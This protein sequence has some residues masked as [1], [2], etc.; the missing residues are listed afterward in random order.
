MQKINL[1]LHDRPIRYTGIG[2]RTPHYQTILE[3]QPNIPW[4]E[5]LS[6]NYFNDPHQRDFLLRLR[7]E[8]PIALHGVGLSLGSTDPLNITYLKQLKSLVDCIQPKLISDHLSWTSVA[9]HH[10]HDL[11]PLPMTDEV[12][13]HVSERIQHVQDYLGRQI[14]IENPSSY[15]GLAMD[16]MPEWEFVNA[17][18]S[19]ADCHVL[20][21]INN[22]A[23][24]AFNQQFNADTYLAEIDA[25]RVKQYHLAG[26][27]DCSDHLFDQHNQ[28]VHEDVWQLYEKAL[29]IIGSKPTLIERDD[30]IPALETLIEEAKR[31]DQ[32]IQQA[33]MTHDIAC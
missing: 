25:T 29:S 32:L 10:L 5:A 12:V 27:T 17:I 21:D 23:V 19:K 6:D 33:E 20:L 28:A 24:S 1:T 14:L 3:Q 22:I 26:Y 8:Y 16:T 2:L 11:L 4:F 31:A 9:H 7:Q 30:N 15:V 13:A 18:A